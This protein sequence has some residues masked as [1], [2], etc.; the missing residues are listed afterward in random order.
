MKT[1]PVETFCS[2][3]FVVRTDDFPQTYYRRPRKITSLLP[4][5]RIYVSGI[6]TSVSSDAR[7]VKEKPMR[8][9]KIPPSSHGVVERRAGVFPP[10]GQR[11][12]ET[13]V[14][15]FPSHPPPH[16]GLRSTLRPPLNSPS[17]PGSERFSA[18]VAARA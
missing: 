5:G 14:L 16:L 2:P 10:L 18:T 4:D 3:D 12:A 7:N 17:F 9:P 13:R 11:P 1:L 8:P 15:V 6:T